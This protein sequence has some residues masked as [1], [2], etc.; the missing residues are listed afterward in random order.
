M[1]WG[2]T[3]RPVGMRDLR[4]S[5]S[6]SCKQNMICEHDV[7]RNHAR[8]PRP[9]HNRTLPSCCAACMHGAQVRYHASPAALN[10][11]YDRLPRAGRTSGATN[12]FRLLPS[13]RNLFSRCVARSA[14][15]SGM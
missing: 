10:A 7:V 15:V 13:S 9:V 4:A 1:G 11:A 6:P 2:Y 8:M 12:I 14:P 5:G 3:C